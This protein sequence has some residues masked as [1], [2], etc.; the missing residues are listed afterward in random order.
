MDRTV[1]VTGGSKLGRAVVGSAHRGGMDRGE[2]RSR[3]LAGQPAHFIRTD[4]TDYG[5]GQR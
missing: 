5:Q 2:L 1:A 3:T 4:L